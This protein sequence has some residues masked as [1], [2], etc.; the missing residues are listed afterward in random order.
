MQLCG[1]QAPLHPK[2]PP[3]RPLQLSGLQG[4][5]QA[6]SALGQAFR[7]C[8]LVYCLS[9]PW[10]AG[11]PGL[12]LADMRKR[13]LAQGGCPANICRRSDP[14]QGDKQHSLP[15]GHSHLL[16]LVPARWQQGRPAV[17]DRRG[18]AGPGPMKTRQDRPRPRE[19]PVKTSKPQGRPLSAVRGPG[20]A[21][22]TA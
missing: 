20:G 9:P 13:S 22:P 3:A 5:P 21:G 15:R 6:S 8:L 2:W 10:L 7:A 4:F 12:H 19:A 11:L 18:R 17:G 16:L 1:R 14:S